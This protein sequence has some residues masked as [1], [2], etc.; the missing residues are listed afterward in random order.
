MV[1]N[2]FEQYLRPTRARPTAGRAHVRYQH[3]YDQAEEMVAHAMLG[4]AVI[5]ALEANVASEMIVLAVH[6][7]IRDYQEEEAG[8]AHPPLRRI[9]GETARRP[10]GQYLPRQRGRAQ[11]T[12]EPDL[13]LP[14]TPRHP[15]TSPRGASNGK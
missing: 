5:G 1:P 6:R 11:G 14:K 12:S 10:P 3:G 9:E 8:Q 4:G 2:V 13:P 7:A 15:V